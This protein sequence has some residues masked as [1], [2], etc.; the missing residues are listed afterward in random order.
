MMEHPEFMNAIARF[1]STSGLPSR[2][3][4]TVR[5]AQPGFAFAL[6]CVGVIGLIA[7]LS[8]NRLRSDEEWARHTAEVIS[9]LR[10][11]LS[12]VT[13]GESAQRGY[14]M[15][16]EEK[17][18]EPYVGA[19]Q[20]VASDLQFLRRLTVDNTAEQHRL[21]LA[22]PLVAKR[23]ARLGEEIELRRTQG[24][25]AAQAATAT[26]VGKQLHDQIRGLVAE[27]EAVEQGLLRQRQVNAI[28]SG[29]LAKAIVGGSILALGLLLAAVWA[30][31]KDFVRRR[32]QAAMAGRLSRMGTWSVEATGFKLTWSDEVCAIHEVPP[33]FAPPVGEALEYYAPECRETI[34]AAFGACVRDGT[35]FDLELELLTARGR[36][37]W[38]RSIG[39]AERDSRGFIRRVQGAFQDITERRHL[40]LELEETKLAAVAREGAQRYS[41]LADTVP[42]IIW[43]ARPDG[44]LDYYNEAWFT[45]TGL[46][47]DEA[48]DWGWGA[49]V[50]PDDLQPCIERWT[51]SFTTGENFETEVRL[52]R[53]ADGACRWHLI[54]SLPR[55]DGEGRIVQWVGTC[56]D[57]DDAVRG[58]ETLQAS[59]EELETRVRERTSELCIAKDA[60]EAASRAKSEFLANMSHEI[61][62]PMNGI[63]GMTDL[64]LDTK[65]DRTQREYLGMAKTSAHGLLG[66]INDILDFSKIE[67][68][69]LEL[70]AISFSLRDCL[71]AMLKP[72]G[73]R[74]EQKGLELTADLPAEVPDHLIGDPMRLRQIL[75][76]LIDNA[77]KFTEHGDVMFGAEIESIADD[78]H[79]LHFTVTDTGI[80]IPGSKVASIFEAFAQVDGSTTRHYGGT[81]LGLAIAAQLVRQMGGRFWVESTLRQGSAF[82]F[83]ARFPVRSTP[84]PGVRYADP[85]Q[86][87]G[88]RVLVVDDHAVN[89]RIMGEILTNWR[90]HPVLVASGPEALVELLSAQRAGMPFPLLLL[91][92][93]MPGM[94]GF[95]VVEKIREHAE[96]AD[97]RVV[98]LSSAMPSGV[99]ARCSEL[100]VSGYLTKPVSQSELLH[101]VLAAI[102][103]LDAVEPAADAA[104]LERAGRV[105]RVLLAEDNV[106]NRALATALL[107][108]RGH[109]LVHAA[110]GR[111]VVEAAAREAFDLILMDVQMPKMDGFEATRRIRESE[112][113]TG[114][115]TPITAMTAHAMAGDRERCLAGGMDDY[116]SK[117]LDKTA[118]CALLERIA[119]DR[120]PASAS[121]PEARVNRTP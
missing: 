63:I 73:I 29:E 31:E 109:S 68:G 6:V 74:A 85:R 14:A 58:K 82:H 1:F 84:V 12:D 106:I 94:D 92:G 79:V 104:P 22:E 111:E 80:G 50:H 48:K 54:R 8:V 45:Y 113:M 60:A 70:E 44:G 115:H 88:L 53:A 120:N 72:L 75:L 7:Y 102:G 98:M 49:V 9:T 32:T 11:L 62:T 25:A 2:S 66:L 93:M 99:A 39:E 56:A 51:H 41:F 90:M 18:L 37:V 47:L 36:R 87:D 89:R 13:D 81:G 5:K 105:L 35:P 21:D 4:S 40:E 97:A 117:P 26:G 30:V 55:R 43:S 3:W 110:D 19:Q 71:G 76:N 103:G 46:T 86:L 16:G 38:V 42:L 64:L 114:R 121:S 108:K 67:A 17:Y 112:I 20:K 78:A 24:F 33:G 28:R 57:I 91:D 27:M 10:L 100:G 118:F 83:T 101:A 96:L 77:I 15:V 119:G 52:K 65:L 107:E 61:R 116:L 69:K 34:T 59:N 95:T 23:M